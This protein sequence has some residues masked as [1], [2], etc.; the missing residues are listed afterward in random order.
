[1]TIS[2]QLELSI[3]IEGF[4]R[5][6]SLSHWQWAGFVAVPQLSQKPH[7]G[8]SCDLLCSAL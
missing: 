7:P 5:L 8:L 2:Y 4:L 3:V 1:M 6:L